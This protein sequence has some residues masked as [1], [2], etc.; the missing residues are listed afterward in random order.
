[1]PFLALLLQAPAADLKSQSIY[2]LFFSTDPVVKVTLI[3]LIG[4]SV[5]S[6]AIILYKYRQVK[7]AK[8]A[9][10]QFLKVFD[11]SYSLDEVLTQ[12]SPREG[13]PVYEVFSSGL[14]DIL[15]VRQMNAK[16]PGR[17]PKLSLEH[18]KKNVYRS[19]GD[20]VAKLELF[21]PFLA[22][23]ASASPFIGL[24][25]TVWGILTAFYAIGKAGSTSL[26]T[27][28]PFISEAL[29]ATAVGLAAAIPAVV[30]YNY[31]IVK[32]RALTK[33]LEDFSV[34]LL[35]RIQKEYF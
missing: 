4:F 2:R 14:S 34:D 6:W 29:I 17:A 15:R 21:T 19:A 27:V 1:M 9:S 26:A 8:N 13:N 32:I 18:V 31:F 7:K 16:D 11:S 24:F 35:Q 12:S 3:V 22:T 10:N 30:A 33:I 20:E 23:T 28:G 25:G 5:F